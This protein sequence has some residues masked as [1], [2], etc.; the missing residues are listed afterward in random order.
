MNVAR[1]F[2]NHLRKSQPDLF[3]PISVVLWIELNYFFKDLF[4]IDLLIKD[5]ENSADAYKIVVIKLQ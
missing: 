1:V 4:D 2:V 3:G 5:F